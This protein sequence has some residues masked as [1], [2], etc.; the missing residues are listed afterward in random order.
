MRKLSVNG[1][2][3]L[4]EKTGYEVEC[5]QDGRAAMDRFGDGDFD[6]VVSDIRMN[7][8]DGLQVLE[9]VQAASA[10]AKVILITGYATVEVARAA[11]A[12]GAFDCI[13]KPF[14]PNELRTVV[15]KAV[16]ALET[17]GEPAPSR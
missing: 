1:S 12:K 5:F 4:L 16:K 11:L 3:P 9:R 17:S 6:I 10:R 8:M 13:A 7:E 15:E 2:I 14:K